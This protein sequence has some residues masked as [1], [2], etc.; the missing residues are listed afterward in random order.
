MKK[1]SNWRGWLIS[2]V[3]LCLG[4][5]A[6]TNNFIGAEHV[7]QVSGGTAILDSYFY[8]PPQSAYQVLTDLGQA[9]RDAYLT[10]N[11]LD[12]FFPLTYGLFLSISLTMTY[13]FVYP[14]QSKRN[15]VILLPLVTMLVDYGENICVRAMLLNYPV[16]LMGTAQVASILTPLKYTLIVV[17]A[18]L[19]LQGNMKVTNK[20]FGKK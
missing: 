3:L 5:F 12:M 6:V 13:T 2:L 16:N 7:K 10:V 19:I 20:L 17:T 4:F 9:G 11:L 15:F 1:I 14:A 8:Y 18:L